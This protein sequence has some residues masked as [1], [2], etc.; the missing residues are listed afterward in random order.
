PPV[1][2]PFSSSLAASEAAA[3]CRCGCKSSQ[4][5]LH[6]NHAHPEISG[7]RIPAGG[8][9]LPHRASARSATTGSVSASH[10][11][12]RGA[13]HAHE[14]RACSRLAFAVRR[15]DRG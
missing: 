6:E 2:T 15:K 4:D 11:Q 10:G 7:N 14:R 1:T 3:P 13:E 8:R 12:H 9:E 5:F